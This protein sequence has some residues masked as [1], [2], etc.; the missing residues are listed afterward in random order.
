MKIEI[1]GPEHID[2]LMALGKAMYEESTLVYLP[3][4]E[5]R[6]R[7]TLLG[8][9]N[10][11]KGVYCMLLARASDGRAAGWLFGT[12]SRPW[13]TSALVAHDHAFFVAPEY[14]GSSAAIKLLGVFRRW[15]EKR[16]AAVLNV[17]QRVGV[18][19]ERFESFMRRAGFEPRGMNFSMRLDNGT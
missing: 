5:N 18:E 17:S 14:R 9:I 1:A 15:A 4:D 6:A 11:D 16:E 7:Q 3:S 2:E 12:I 8:A 19:M 10:D 13:F